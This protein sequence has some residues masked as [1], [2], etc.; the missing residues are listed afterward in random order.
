MH[1]DL[2]VRYGPVSGTVPGH[3]N[4]TD[5]GAFRRLLLHADLLVLCNEKA[6]AKDGFRGGVGRF[7]NAR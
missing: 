4:G 1:C 5:R 2:V 6:K 3:A 7:Y